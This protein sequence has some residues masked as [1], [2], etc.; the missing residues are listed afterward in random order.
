MA[1][2]HAHQEDVLGRPLLFGAQGRDS[3]RAPIAYRGW[4]CVVYL[5]ACK[6]KLLLPQKFQWKTLVR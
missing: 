6:Q 1:V 2:G 3:T 4:P 5:V